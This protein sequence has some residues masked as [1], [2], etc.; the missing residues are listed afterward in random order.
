MTM[1][2]ITVLFTVHSAHRADFLA[3]MVNNARLSL[4]REPGCRQFDVCTVIKSADDIFLYEIYDSRAAFDAHLASEHFQQ[5]NL[6]TQPWVKTK[7]VSALT[8][9]WP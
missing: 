2:V 7:V 5:F 9:A 8:K 4:E 1:Y 6:K 3:E